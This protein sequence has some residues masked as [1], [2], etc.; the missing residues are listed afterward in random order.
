MGT[1]R[2]PAPTHPS[3][4]HPRPIP[5]E[6]AFNFRDLGGR[7]AG[8]G[9]VRTRLV[10]RSDGLHRLSPADIG[11]LRRLGIRT[12]IDLRS[13]EECARFGVCDAA[14]LPA[15]YHHV[16]LVEE[17]WPPPAEGEPAGTWLAARY[18]DLLETSA[19][20][21]VAVLALL[22][23]AGTWPVVFH[24]TGGK[25]RTGVVAAV[26][27]ALLGVSDE[28]IVHD[29]CRSTPGITW[30]RQSL[31]SGLDRGA[32][33]LEVPAAIFE[34][35]AEAMRLFLDV[36]AAEHGSMPRWA[37]AAGTP[38]SLVAALRAGLVV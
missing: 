31:E 21:I 11:R 34:V 14:R 9:S 7:R 38:P 37:L 10:Y 18:R 6:G 20:G 15:A 19:D 25:D 3:M 17:P 12:V 32:A 5:L 24:C 30:L 22:A 16:P 8:L 26:V 28:E 29:Y 35:P 27:L 4:L 13:S 2:P 36:V 33:G 23:D 1:T